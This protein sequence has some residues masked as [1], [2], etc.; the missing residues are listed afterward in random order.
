[1]SDE[2]AHSRMALPY[3]LA[4][5]IPETRTHTGDAA[6][7]ARLGVTARLGSRASAI[8]A[9]AKIVTLSD[10]TRL[11]FD[12]LLMATGSSPVVPAIAGVDLPGVL[13]RWTLDHTARVL[14][15]AEALAATGRTLRVALIG[16]GFIGFIVLNAMFKRKW[17]LTVIER[18]AQV[19]PRMLDRGAAAH[20]ERW[21][22][23]R[24]IPVHVGTT[25]QR[26]D[27]GAEGAKSIVVSGGRSID[28]DIVIVAT[29]VRP[30]LQLARS[31][32]LATADGIL[33]DERMRTSV[34]HIYA[35]GDVAQGPVLGSAERAVHAIQTTAVDHGRVAGANMAG[36][37]VLY[38]GS[39]AMNVVDVC[40]LQGA[41]FGSSDDASAEAMTID[42]AAG[43]VYRKLL[44]TEDRISGALFVGRPDD[45][46][47]LT[48]IGMVKGLIQCRSRLGSWKA[49]LSAH[50]HDVRR[51][52][53]ASG[54]AATLA[55]TTLLG[56][57]ST[58]RGF[59]HEQDAGRH[60]PVKPAHA[61]FLGR[62]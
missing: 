29:G 19:L 12:D 56:R 14:K 32:G 44:W 40:G 48:D 25:V 23:A 43:F 46:G 42:N 58:P 45:L 4:G 21:L 41:A 54:V 39:L 17:R 18:E 1:V 24:D 11:P 26:I 50:P 22:A 51:A 33:V 37:D 10:G 2:I 59:V 8:D 31:A 13:P 60:A 15:H 28:A 16:A 9:A 62:T 3:W 52:Y 38:P 27:A 30:N 36:Q 6:Y 49:H 20:V 35:A 5:N 47:M 61:V 55:R 53:A 34:P 57:A 7:F